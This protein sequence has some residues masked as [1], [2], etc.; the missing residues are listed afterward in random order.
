MPVSSFG[1]GNA[2]KTRTTNHVAETGNVT[3]TI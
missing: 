2:L 1:N 3:V